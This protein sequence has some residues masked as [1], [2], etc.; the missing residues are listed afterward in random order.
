MSRLFRE[1]GGARLSPSSP[2]SGG[3]G[4]HT[5]MAEQFEHVLL[6]RLTESQPVCSARSSFTRLSRVRSTLSG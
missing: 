2:D 6:P 5:A 3:L 1:T 4:G